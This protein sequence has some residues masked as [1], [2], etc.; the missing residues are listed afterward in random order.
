M[1]VTSRLSPVNS[2]I[3]PLFFLF[4]IGGLSYMLALV[5]IKELTEGTVD[6]LF[7]TPIYG[8]IV[9]IGLLIWMAYHYA[10]MCKTIQIG[11]DGLKFSGIFKS[12]LI[13]WDEVDKIKLTGKKIIIFSPMEAT[14]IKLKNGSQRTIVAFYYENMDSMRRALEQVNNCIKIRKPVEIIQRKRI[15]VKIEKVGFLNTVG[16]TKYSGNH[17]ISFNGIMI[18]GWVIFFAYLGLTTESPNSFETNLILFICVFGFFYGLMGFQLHYY[19]MDKDFLVIKNHVWPWR[20]HRYRISDIKQAVFETPYRMST[21][22][23]I[24]TKDYKSTL[25]PGGSLNDDT[26]EQLLMEFKNLKVSVRNE[27]IY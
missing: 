19:Y 21:S 7:K 4:F 11:E 15:P 3:S 8:S 24:I 23:R 26:W 13:K 9:F 14:H 22:L 10:K 17:F 27:A 2:I 20:I 1:K 5:S 18:Y 16:M 6:S 12:E 25:Y